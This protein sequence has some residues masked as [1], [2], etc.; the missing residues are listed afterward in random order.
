MVGLKG[1]TITIDAIGTQIE[2]AQT[3]IGGK[4]GY[5]LALKDNQPTLLNDIVLYLDTEIIPQKK[6]SLKEAGLYSKTVEKGHDRI[7]TKSVI[8]ATVLIGWNRKC[9]GRLS[10][11][12]SN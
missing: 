7:E 3:I 10:R 8:F 4:G 12:R 11:S 2:I 1:K 9:V 6:T 5:L